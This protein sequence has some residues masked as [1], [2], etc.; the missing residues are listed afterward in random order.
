MNALSI[1]SLMAIG[2]GLGWFVYRAI[3]RI[4]AWGEN[5]NRQDHIFR[6]ATDAEYEGA[7]RRISVSRF[8]EAPLD[9]ASVDAL[10]VK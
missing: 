3:L 2:A 7:I 10:H 1:A 9:R 8:E 6:C 4:H 5:M